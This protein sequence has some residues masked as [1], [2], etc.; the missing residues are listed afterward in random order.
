M[1]KIK[2]PIHNKIKING[3]GWVFSPKDFN[4]IG[5]RNSTDKQLSRFVENGTI[6]RLGRGLYD[7]PEKNPNNDNYKKPTLQAI[8]RALETQLGENFQYSGQYAALLL[9]LSKKLHPQITYLIRGRSRKIKIA[10]YEI[11]LKHTSIPAPKNKKDKATLI[12]QALIHLN[13]ERI[14][15][16]TL[17]VLKKQIDLHDIRRLRKLNDFIPKWLQNYLSKKIL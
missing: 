12:I 16:E 3:R 13:R 5:D 8:I 14:N 9:G 2:E 10:G 11:N 7:F 6:R 15:D 17:Q 4:S 1:R